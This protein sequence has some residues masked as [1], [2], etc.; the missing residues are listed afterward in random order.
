VVS[1]SEKIIIAPITCKTSEYP[2]IAPI[3]YLTGMDGAALSICYYLYR[4]A[5][6]QLDVLLFFR[7]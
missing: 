3:N 5:S 4:I 1:M 6:Y 7:T 2:I